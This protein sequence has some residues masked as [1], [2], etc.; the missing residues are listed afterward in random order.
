MGSSKF[1][2][3]K[4]NGIY[5]MWII[6]A[7]QCISPEVTVKGFMKC[8]I[9]NAVEGTDDGMFWNGREEDGNV[10]C[11]SEERGL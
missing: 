7:W 6:M 3:K 10:W 4:Y 2:T 5:A 9:A 1:K 8:C 11:E